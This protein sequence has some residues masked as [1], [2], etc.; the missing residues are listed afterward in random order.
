MVITEFMNFQSAVNL[1]VSLTIGNS[2]GTSD[3]MVDGLVLCMTK[4]I[5]LCSLQL[6]IKLDIVEKNY[7]ISHRFIETSVLMQFN[8]L[9]NF[10]ALKRFRCKNP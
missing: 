9:I 1:I 3:F 8:I 10:H 4:Q 6:T 2:R 7:K 5:L